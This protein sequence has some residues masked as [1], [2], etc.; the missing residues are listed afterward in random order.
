MQNELS[1]FI[2][3]GRAATYLGIS[4]DTLRRWEK[5]GKIIS[6]RLDGK[7]RYFK[8]SDVDNLKEGNTYDI[9]EA[10]KYLGISASTLRRRLDT[11]EITSIKD[12]HNYQR[13]RKVDLDTYISDNQAKPSLSQP[14][15]TGPEVAQVTYHPTPVAAFNVIKSLGN[16]TVKLPI[17]LFSIILSMQKFPKIFVTKYWKILLAVII[18][19]V[20]F[21][22]T[23]YFYRRYQSLQK[24][25]PTQNSLDDENKKLIIKLSE[26]LDL[27]SGETPTVAVVTDPEK[28]KDQPFFAKAKKGDK[29][30]IYP[31]ARQAILYDAGRNKILE[32]NRIN[33]A[34]STNAPLAQSSLPVP[35]NSPSPKIDSAIQNTPFTVVLYNGT[36]STGLTF[37]LEQKL[38]ENKFNAKIIDRDS[39]IRKDYTKTL[40]VDLNTGKSYIGERLA[41][42]LHA[43]LV[44]ELPAGEIK[45]VASR[46]A[47]PI[48]FLIIAGKEAI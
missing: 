33:L 1:E 46:S 31:N 9:A 22:P 37:S 5:A 23:F 29:V 38:K 21:T 34:D 32:Y 30:I 45:P 13:F 48:D 11:S 14:M 24:N 40:V 2:P 36:N 41:E 39:A 19:A 17:K 26:I 47:T 10:A 6:K 18:L 25:I 8:R 12:A 20:A 15:Q 16:N 3:I 7:N 28:L 44:R 35:Q 4:I 43:D 27:P 42:I